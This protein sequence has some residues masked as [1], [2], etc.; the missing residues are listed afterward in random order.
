MR[1]ALETPSDYRGVQ[2]S[3]TSLLPQ[4]YQEADLKGNNFP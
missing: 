1:S 4:G 3:S 2:K